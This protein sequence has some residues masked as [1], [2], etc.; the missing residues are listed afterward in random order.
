MPAGRPRLPTAL[1]KA[2]RNL[3]TMPGDQ[4]RSDILTVRHGCHRSLTGAARKEWQRIAPQLRSL[5]LL[6]GLRCCGPGR[7]TARQWGTFTEANTIIQAEGLMVDGKAHRL[8]KVRNDA[9]AQLKL[10]LSEFGLS[11]SSR[12]KL[13]STKPKAQDDEAFLFSMN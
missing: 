1:K 8:I 5:G 6:T 2:K 9:S 7:L 3:A 12:S 13:P 10:F 11:P 4:Q